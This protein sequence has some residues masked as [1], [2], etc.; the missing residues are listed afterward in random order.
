M[1]QFIENKVIKG[2]KTN[3]IGN[4]SNT[5]NSI[6]VKKGMQR[7]GVL[8]TSSEQN[9]I[10]NTGTTSQR[11]VTPVEGET[12]YNTSLSR[13]ETYVSG[14]WTAIGSTYTFTNGLTSATNN[15]KLGGTLTAATTVEA[16]TYKLSLGATAAG[17]FSGLVVNSGNG[18]YPN[19]LGNL[20]CNFNYNPTSGV[21]GTVNQ[22]NNLYYTQ[23]FSTPYVFG[24]RQMKVALF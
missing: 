2:K 20:S 6:L 14:T 16:S 11:S 22:S 3:H 9:L 7:L 19:Y 23:I 8:N 21:L 15:V 17:T 4:A 13:M 5:D 24:I 1:S 18:L 10:I 12:R